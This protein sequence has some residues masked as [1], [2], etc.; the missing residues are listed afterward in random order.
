MDTMLTCDLTGIPMQQFSGLKEPENESYL[1]QLKQ[2]TPARVGIGRAGARYTTAA[3][4]RFQADQYAA[5]EAVNTEVPPEVVKA[6]GLFE[7]RTR[8]GS[9]Y[10]M[11]THPDLGREFDEE[12]KMLISDRCRHGVDVQLYVGDGLCAPAVAADVP[13]LLPGITAAL[14][15]DG[16]SVGIPFFVRYCRVNTAQTVSELLHPQVTCVLIGERPGL[17]T[18]ESMSAYMAYHAGY[19]MA[20]SDYTVVSNISGVG[21]P[22]VEA[23]AHIAGILEAML[24]QKTSGYGLKF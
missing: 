4:L 20:E 21:L 13:D 19:H 3:A 10:E 24:E 2:A 18:H 1:K 14:T 9:K 16:V 6:L 5:A 12:T 22:P 15:Y 8:C 17:L 23:A 7:V 11:L